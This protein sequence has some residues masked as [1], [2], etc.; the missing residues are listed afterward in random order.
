MSDGGPSVSAP[1]SH[2]LP[3]SQYAS[4]STSTSNRSLNSS[5]RQPTLEQEQPPQSFRDAPYYPQRHSQE[6]QNSPHTGK[7]RLYCRFIRIRSN[8]LE[9]RLSSAITRAHA[10]NS[11]AARGQYRFAQLCSTE[12]QRWS[13]SQA[14]STCNIILRVSSFGY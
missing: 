4:M 13:V 8:C 11:T 6:H 5:L 9:R 7:P 12:S 1:S 10:F 2:K 14:I 3:P